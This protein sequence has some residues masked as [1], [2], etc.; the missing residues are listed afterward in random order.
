[1]R[2]EWYDDYLDLVEELEAAIPD[3]D[4]DEDDSMGGYYSRN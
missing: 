3:G 2:A 4:E 1:V